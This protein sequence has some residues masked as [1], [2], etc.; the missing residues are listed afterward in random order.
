[1]QYLNLKQTE[2]RMNDITALQ[3]HISNYSRTREIY[4]QYRKSGYSKN[5]LEAHEQDIRLHKAAK[6][7]FDAQ[8]LKKLPTIKMLQNEYATLLSQKKNSMKT[9]ALLVV[10]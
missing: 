5:F 3:K 6:Q 7:A 2:K 10:K 9:I 4:T 1:M 8:N